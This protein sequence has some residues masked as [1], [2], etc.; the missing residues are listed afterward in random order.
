MK[1]LKSSLFLLL[2]VLLSSLV[3]SCKK[4]PGKV[5]G[6]LPGTWMVSEAKVGTGGGT[7]S[8]VKISDGR[9]IKLIINQNGSVSGDLFPEVATFTV[10]DNTHLQVKLKDGY[11][12]APLTFEYT[13]QGE[14]LEIK[15][16]CM[17][18]CAYRFVK[19]K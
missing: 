1:V 10:V 5:H 7:P 4:D 12:E 14:T 16:V 2:A 13:L 15:G 18:G 17:E 11:P 9:E 19:V 3:L 6:T 8:W